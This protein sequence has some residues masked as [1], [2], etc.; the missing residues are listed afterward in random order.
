M[1]GAL[2]VCLGWERVAPCTAGRGRAS[3]VGDAEEV[4]TRLMNGP[5]SL[6]GGTHLGRSPVSLPW[7]RGKEARMS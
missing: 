1:V 3:S 7:T 6:G 2:L 4:G 5:R